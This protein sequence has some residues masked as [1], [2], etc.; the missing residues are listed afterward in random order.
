[1]ISNN[2]QGRTLS[3]RYPIGKDLYFLLEG[4]KRLVLNMSARL[5]TPER[6]KSSLKRHTTSTFIHSFILFAI[7]S[8]FYSN[9][10]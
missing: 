1:M 9:F 4:H 3:V 2:M 5:R 7:Y 6:V 10:I 8:I